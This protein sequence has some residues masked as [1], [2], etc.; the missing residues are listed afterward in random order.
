[1]VLIFV[2]VTLLVVAPLI[3][4]LDKYFSGQP[5]KGPLKDLKGKYA[6]ITGGS[7]GIG[8]ATALR[9]AKQGCHI[10]IGDIEK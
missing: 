8:R 2:I 1:M 10:I 4:L 5:Y 7:S 6:I 9:L 3:F